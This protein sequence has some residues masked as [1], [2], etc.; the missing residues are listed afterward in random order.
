MKYIQRLI[1]N[2]ILPKYAV[3]QLIL[4]QDNWIF[5]ADISN[6]TLNIKVTLKSTY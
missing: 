3:N 5:N 6:D 2:D 1:M 4:H